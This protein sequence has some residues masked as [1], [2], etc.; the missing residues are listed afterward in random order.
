MVK[1]PDGQVFYL[2][3]LIVFL[4]YG[5][6]RKI[7]MKMAYH[8]LKAN[9][10]KSTKKFHK[11]STFLFLP[12]FLVSLISINAHAKKLSDYTPYN[13]DVLFTNPDCKEHTY[14]DPINSVKGE[15]IYNKPKNAYCKP[16]ENKKVEE[17]KHTPFYRIKEWIRDP[18][19]KE[20]FMAYLSFSKKAIRDELCTAIKERGLKLTLIVDKNNKKR[21]MESLLDLKSC[22]AFRIGQDGISIPEVLTRGGEG[23]GKNKIGFAHNKLI[24]I[25]PHQKGKVKLAF[26]SGNMSNGTTTHHEN[27]HFITTNSESYFFQSHLC[28]KKGLLDHASSIDVFTIFIKECR[29]TIEAPEETD[30]KAFF[31]PAEGK[32]AMEALKSEMGHA[33]E[34]RMATHRFSSKEIIASMEEALERGAH[35]QFVFDD[36][37]YWTS[38]LKRGMGRNL[39]REAVHVDNL[40]Q[41]GLKVKYIETFADSV[42]GAR[43]VQLQHNKFLI[44]TG[45][46]HDSYSVFTGAGNLT[47]AAFQ[48]NFENFYLIKDPAVYFM[49]RLQYYRF[50][51]DMGTAAEDMPERLVLP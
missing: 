11:I 23:R 6:D 4:I 12:I 25:N 30:I 27:W 5:L 34:I 10:L 38:K 43:K 32:E 2:L 9:K 13:Y 36:D 39:Y 28:L 26:S 20:I 45:P 35:I 37:L 44:F 48:K 1:A 19:T 21:G 15:L 18:E 40:I 17:Q 29:A 51:N 14:K 49:F 7:I 42:F 46:M 24:L 47:G 50:W 33:S 41:K 3:G 31:V 16:E 8:N 22:P